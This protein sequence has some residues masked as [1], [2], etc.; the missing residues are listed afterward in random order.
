MQKN[1]LLANPGASDIP[2]LRVWERRPCWSW[3]PFLVV[4]MLPW[5]GLSAGGA[6]AAPWCL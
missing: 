5:D 4:W 1:L 2:H 3:V 6:A